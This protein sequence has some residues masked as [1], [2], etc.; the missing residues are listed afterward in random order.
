M[1]RSAVIPSASE[2]ALAAVRVL[3]QW[4]DATHDLTA[5]I[6]ALSTSPMQRATVAP[7]ARRPG[8]ARGEAVGPETHGPIGFQ[9]ALACFA[10]AARP[11]RTWAP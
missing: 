10:E 11:G 4:L 3:S 8:G 5:S 9:V 6:A 2:E 7:P 1:S